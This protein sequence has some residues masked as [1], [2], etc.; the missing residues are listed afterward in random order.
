MSTTPID[1]DWQWIDMHWQKSS[2]LMANRRTIPHVTRELVYYAESLLV[3]TEDDF[4]R[5]HSK[6]FDRSIPIQ[7]ESGSNRVRIHPNLIPITCQSNVDPAPIQHEFSTN[8]VLIR[9]THFNLIPFRCQSNVNPIPMQCQSSSIWCQSIWNPMSIK[10]Q[11]KSQSSANPFKYDF[12]P[13]PT[14]CRSS[15]NPSQSDAN[16]VKCQYSTNQSPTRFQSISNPMS[17][18]SHSITIQCQAGAKLK[19]IRPDPMQIQ[20]KSNYNQASAH[21][22]PMPIWC[23][24]CKHCKCIQF[25]DN[26]M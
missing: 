4:V 23:Q 6:V 25:D 1:T 17:I 8:L 26:P 12:N 22:N 13:I 16:P 10:S 15:V 24:Y 20:R 11:S 21:R 19:S 7:S 9:C 18:K 5:R 2:Q 3:S 14:W